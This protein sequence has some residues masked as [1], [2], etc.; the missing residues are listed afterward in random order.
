MTFVHAPCRE[1]TANMH[2]RHQTLRGEISI[3]QKAKY[4]WRQQAANGT[5]RRTVS[6]KASRED[7]CAL[8]AGVGSD[9]RTDGYTPYAE[10]PVLQEHHGRH[11]GHHRWQ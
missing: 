1:S 10:R 8:H 11:A 3:A 6:H 2:D 7:S 4:N 5:R 9:V